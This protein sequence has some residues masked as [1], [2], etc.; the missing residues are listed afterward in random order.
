MA[1]MNVI[2]F[3][4]CV[5]LLEQDRKRTAIHMSA[6]FHPA[7]TEN[8]NGKV[9]VIATFNPPDGEQTITTSLEPPTNDNIDPPDGEQPITTSLEPRKNETTIP[10]IVAPVV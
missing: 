3:M 10:T 1:T 4:F 9:E 7:S 6:T 8:P 2:M 5:Y